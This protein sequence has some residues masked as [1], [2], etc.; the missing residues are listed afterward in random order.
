MTP[1][2]TFIVVKIKLNFRARLPLI[3]ATSTQLDSPLLSMPLSSVSDSELWV[4]LCCVEDPEPL[5][6]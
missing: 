3:N 5:A 4:P 2:F 1:L 6:A